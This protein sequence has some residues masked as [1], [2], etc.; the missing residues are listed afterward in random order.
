M[1]GRLGRKD[2]LLLGAA[3][4]CVV[5]LMTFY[6]WQQTES[7]RLGYQTGTLVKRR[8]DLVEEIKT[9]ET[10]RAALLALERVERIA[11]EELGLVDPREDQI[12]YHDFVF[13]QEGW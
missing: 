13:G 7:I 2:I 4:A 1:R 10:R 6:L 11:R 5:A 9:L 8:A 3:A 12:I